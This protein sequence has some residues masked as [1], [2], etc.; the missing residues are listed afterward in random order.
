[1]PLNTADAC[2]L[3]EHVTA[4][5]RDELD[6]AIASF[7]RTEDALRHLLDELDDRLADL[8][9]ERLDGC[10]SSVSFSAPLP[11]FGVGG[12]FSCATLA[13]SNGVPQNNQLAG[14]RLN[15]RS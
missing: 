6:E 3:H 13:Q 7:D 1:M 10:T 12:V 11:P 5:T 15:H 2:R 9:A 8:Q 4:L 14:G